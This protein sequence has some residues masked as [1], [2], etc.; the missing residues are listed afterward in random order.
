MSTYRAGQYGA[1]S[2]RPATATEA[3]REAGL[4][5]DVGSLMR[6]ITDALRAFPDAR[7]AVIAAVRRAEASSA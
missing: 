3:K 2:S 4:R 7:A 5:A 1:R 6:T